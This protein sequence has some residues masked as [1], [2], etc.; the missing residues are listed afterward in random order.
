LSGIDK[1]D[2]EL[3]THVFERLSFRRE[4]VEVFRKVGD[5]LRRCGEHEL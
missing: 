2:A 3:V 1:G 4:F 5:E